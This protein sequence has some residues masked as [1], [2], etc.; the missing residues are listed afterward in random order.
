[1]VKTSDPLLE[2]PIR[3]PAGTRI[4]LQT[5]RSADEPT[6]VVEELGIGRSRQTA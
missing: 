1:M 4:N 3:P 2:G 6:Q 5:Q